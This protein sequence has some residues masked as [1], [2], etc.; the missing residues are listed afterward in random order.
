VCKDIAGLKH[1]ED[2]WQKNRILVMILVICFYLNSTT[3]VT[4]VIA[5]NS[6]C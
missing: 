5:S 3:S 2:Y 6:I 1:S 4:N